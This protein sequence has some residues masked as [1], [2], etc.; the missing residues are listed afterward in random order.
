MDK[1]RHDHGLD[2]LS[3]GSSR[4]IAN[5]LLIVRL[6]E[7]LFPRLR[8]VQENA[9]HNPE[10]WREVRDWIQVCQAIRLEERSLV[11]G[12]GLQNRLDRAIRLAS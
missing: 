8:S 1:C 12:S 5:M 7:R 6:L 2:T 3:T 11:R 4:R 10:Q 9:G